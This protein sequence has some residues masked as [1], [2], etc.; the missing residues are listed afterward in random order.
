MRTSQMTDLMHRHGGVVRTRALVAAGAHHRDITRAIRGEAVLR[1]REGVYALPST[2]PHVMTAASHGGELACVS[3]LRA[4]GVWVLDP[5]GRPHVWLGTKGRVHAH[6]GCRCIDHHD[7]GHA[8]FGVTGLSL[9]LVQASRCAGEECFFVAYESA[10]NKGLIDRAER[11]WIRRSVPARYKRLVDLARAD[12]DSG[13]E[14]L[15]RLRL[16][17]LGI[18]LDCQ[19]SIAGVGRVDFVAAGRL[20]IE[21]DGEQNHGSASHR[22]KD[23]VRD[24]AAAALGYATLRFD[25]ALV[26]HDWPTVERAVLARL[27]ALRG[28]VVG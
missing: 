2:D 18:A 27:Q 19:V 26:V 24:A 13:L 3:A 23:L 10:W 6:G 5:P 4:L 25:Y 17:R 11:D 20:I 21:V 15:L 14:S 9:A 28:A 8:T 16:S 22:H 12:A 1:V 7:A